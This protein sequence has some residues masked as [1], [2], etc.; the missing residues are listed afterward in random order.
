MLKDV[1]ACKEQVDDM[2]VQGAE[3]SKCKLVLVKAV[4]SA[5]T[6]K[7]YLK[8]TDGANSAKSTGSKNSSKTKK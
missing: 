2:I 3:E 7:K 5:V 8:D 6:L 4:K 1:K